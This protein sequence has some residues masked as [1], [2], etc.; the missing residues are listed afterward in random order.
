MGRVNTSA[1]EPKKAGKKRRDDHSLEQLKEEN[2]KLRDLAERRSATMAHLGH[3]L[4]TPLTSI[5]GFSEIL[6]SQEELTDAQ[7]NF[8]ERIQNSAQQL[9]RTLNHM[10]DLSRTDTPDE[11]ASGS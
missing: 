3:E 9:Q 4:R 6:L 5:L 11:N 10:A 7:R 2:R 8:C 1:A